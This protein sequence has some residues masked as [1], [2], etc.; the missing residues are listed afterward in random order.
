MAA[1]AHGKACEYAI[2]ENFEKEVRWKCDIPQ[3]IGRLWVSLSLLSSRQT[4]LPHLNGGEPQRRANGARKSPLSCYARTDPRNER[5]TKLSTSSLWRSI[6]S[7]CSWHD[8][9]ASSPS[10]NEPPFVLLL[11]FEKD[12]PSIQRERNAFPAYGC[13]RSFEKRREEW[14]GGCK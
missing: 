13:R 14:H 6:Y 11:P 3:E 7:R 2:I 1:L 10:H 8:L 12:T 9:H 5:P 4:P